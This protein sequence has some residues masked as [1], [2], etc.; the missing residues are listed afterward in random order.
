[1]A[2]ISLGIESRLTTVRLNR[3]DPYLRLHAINIYVR[4]LDRSLEFYAEKLGFHVALDRRLQFGQR[5]LAVAPPDG[6]GVLRLIAASPDSDTYALIGRPTQIVFL[7]EDVLAKYREWSKRGVRFRYTPRLRR[8]KYETQGD[9]A[10]GQSDVSPIWGGV[11][12]R[13][14]DIDG[15]SFTLVGLDEVSKELEAQRRAIAEKL[16]AERRVAQELEIARQVQARLFPQNLPA[17]GTLEYAGVCVQARQVGGDYY[18]FLNLGH[19]RVGLIVGDIAGKGIAAALLMAN[20]QA[21][22]RSQCATALVHPQQFLE[23][24]NQLFYEN[25]A[26]SAYATLFFGEYDDRARKL[27]YANCGHLPGLLLR[28]DQTMERLDSTGTVLGLFS[29]WSCTVSEC[30]LHPGDTLAL[31]TDGVTESFNDRDEEFG[32]QR[33]IEGLRN[34]CGLRPQAVVDSLL[35][36]VK[37]FSPQEQHDDITLI[38]ARCRE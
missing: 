38:V 22:L 1:M 10:S 26:E 37:K 14:E 8:I 34:C 18:D 2:G 29:N 7:T 31:Y 28:K 25:T 20:L 30:D 5:L 19:G 17:A 12:T 3:Q 9:A 35:H 16:E 23:S 6:T 13:F 21:N 4:D 33:L 36:D 24:V 32:E 27:R 15:N 11:F